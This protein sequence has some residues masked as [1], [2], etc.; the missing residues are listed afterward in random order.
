[1]L[2][3]PKAQGTIRF[4]SERLFFLVFSSLFGLNVV[5]CR[6]WVMLTWFANLT[7]ANLIAGAA[8][9][10]AVGGNAGGYVVDPSVTL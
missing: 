1:V 6:I 5:P 8:H 4:L 2:F 10:I 7:L 3:A 9:G